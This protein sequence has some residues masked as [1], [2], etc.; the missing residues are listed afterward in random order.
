MIAPSSML[1]STSNSS[2]KFLCDLHHLLKQI[3]GTDGSIDSS[4]SSSSSSSQWSLSN[5]IDTRPLY[6]DICS[7]YNESFLYHQQHNQQHD[8]QELFH[9]IM[10]SLINIQYQQQ[11]YQQQLSYFTIIIPTFSTTNI[12]KIS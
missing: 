2:I 11:Q 12:E 4:H 1:L 10:D 7:H 8:A 9:A 6:Q 3:N 5:Y